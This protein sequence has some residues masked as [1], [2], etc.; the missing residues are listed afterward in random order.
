MNSEEIEQL[1]PKG[2][3]IT[4]T[5]SKVENFGAFADL[6]KGITGYIPTKELSW[7]GSVLDAREKLEPNQ[8]VLAKIIS[9]D[10]RHQSITLSPKSA[11][12]NPWYHFAK[13][14]Q[15]NDIVKGR[16]I[17]VQEKAAFLE[18]DGDVEGII[19]LSHAWLKVEKME[20][21]LLV[22]DNVQTKIL[23][24]DEKEKVAVLSV[25]GL[26]KDEKNYTESESTWTLYDEFPN[27]FDMLK[28][29]NEKETERKTAIAVNSYKKIKN[30]LVINSDPNLN[31]SVALMLEGFEFQI[32]EATSS[33]KAFAALEKNAVDLIIADLNSH[34]GEI[35]SFLKDIK[36]RFS[37]IEI[38][39]QVTLQTVQEKLNDIF[40]LGLQNHLLVKPWKIEKLIEMINFAA[41]GRFPQSEILASASE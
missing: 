15:Q 41:E 32:F 40:Q 38:I 35:I 1:Y 18:L 26:Y 7:T 29:Q 11:R 3:S 19:P 30:I 9:I 27:L 31:L 28:Y 36:K 23:Y 12:E 6:E 8:H 33:E 22:N 13:T 25:T 5:I 20:D 14:H 17:R 37:K 34:P 16:V 4:V 24:L 10:P 2:E 39:L 21:A